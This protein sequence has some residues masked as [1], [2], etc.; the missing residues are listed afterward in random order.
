MSILKENY[1]YRQVLS[2]CTTSKE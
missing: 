2:D 1:R